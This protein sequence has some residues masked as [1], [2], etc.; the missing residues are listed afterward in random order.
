MSKFRVLIFVSVFAVNYCQASNFQ[1]GEFLSE[2]STLNNAFNPDLF[3]NE[4]SNTENCGL[5]G[6]LKCVRYQEQA[7]KERSFTN[8]TDVAKPVAYDGANNNY[9]NPNQIKY[10]Q[11]AITNFN[12]TNSN[13]TT[14]QAYAP[15]LN[16]TDFTNNPVGLV[17][18]N[19]VIPIKTG[20]NSLINVG[21]N[22]VELN[23]KY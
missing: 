7:P 19:A 20:E 23:L 13:Q 5:I 11:N 22:K 18:Q 4:R 16:P 10:N 8:S 14:L 2:A 1:S 12:M 17:K 9:V 6:S 15:A 21:T 3:T